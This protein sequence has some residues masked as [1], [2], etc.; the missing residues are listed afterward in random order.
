MS[1]VADFFTRKS[2]KLGTTPGV[3]VAPPRQRGGDG[4]DAV[5]RYFEAGESSDTASS[6]GCGV[7][8]GVVVLCFVDSDDDMTEILT[9][10]GKGGMIWEFLSG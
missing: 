9:K 7:M 5:R 3:G 1:I 8:G 2:L 4:T 6:V 10:A